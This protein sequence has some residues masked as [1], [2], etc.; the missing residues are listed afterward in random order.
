MKEKIT[1]SVTEQDI[2]LGVRRNCSSCPVALAIKRKLGHGCV[3]VLP[4]VVW[5]GWCPSYATRLPIEATKA[6][7]DFD[8][9]ETIKPF[10]FE[11][12][13]SCSTR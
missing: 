4:F 5:I 9:G 2:I 13:V 1:V 12:E 7:D 8:N 6:L 10:S 11:L 3:D